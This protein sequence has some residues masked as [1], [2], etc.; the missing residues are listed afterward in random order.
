MGMGMKGVRLRGLDEGLWK[1]RIARMYC[2]RKDEARVNIINTRGGARCGCAGLLL[3][4]GVRLL[5][6]HHLGVMP[7]ALLTAWQPH[8]HPRM[9]LFSAVTIVAWYGVFVY[10]MRR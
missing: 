10:R 8:I 6:F 4:H 7:S 5:S 3:R 1:H 9:I 2:I